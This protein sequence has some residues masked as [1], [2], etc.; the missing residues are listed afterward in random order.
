MQ[1]QQGM[2]RGQEIQGQRKNRNPG[3]YTT[4]HG[5]VKRRSA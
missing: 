1:K 4:V 5:S 2:K 3:K